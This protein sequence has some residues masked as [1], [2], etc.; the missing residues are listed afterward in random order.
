MSETLTVST[1]EEATRDRDSAGK[2]AGSVG[3]RLIQPI[4]F[5]FRGLSEGE[6]WED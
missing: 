4:Y 6:D 1:D 2:G 5:P 3:A